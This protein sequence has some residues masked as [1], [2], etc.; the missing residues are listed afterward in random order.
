MSDVVDGDQIFARW[1]QAIVHPRT[2]E[3]LRSIFKKEVQPA[4]VTPSRDKKGGAA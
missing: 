1:S 4:R 3:L 2:L